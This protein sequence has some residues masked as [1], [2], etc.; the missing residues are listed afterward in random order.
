MH[1]MMVSTKAGVW[2]RGAIV[3]LLALALCGPAAPVHANGTPIRIVLSYLNG[4]SNV[5]PQNATGV[6]ELITSEGE[7]RLTAAGLQ[8]LPDNE[9][10]AL[11]ISS[12]A[13]KENLLLTP[14]SVGDGGVA[15]VDVVLRTPI[16]EKPWDLMVLTVESKGATPGAPSDRHAIAGRFPTQ[17]EGSAPRVLPNT[18]GDVPPGAPSA[19]VA[20]WFGLS[21][22]GAALLI[23]LV[24]GAVGY[25]LGRAGA[26]RGA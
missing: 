13:T 14:V 3:A 17:G 26:R 25:A 5:G 7:V 9:Q 12:D 24:A 10:Y 16:P 21:G 15:R 11:W 22:A 4:V 18:G 6:A 23:L 1:E 2:A 19:P 8:K 20:G